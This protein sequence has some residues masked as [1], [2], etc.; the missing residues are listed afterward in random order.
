MEGVL[1]CRPAHLTRHAQS[2]R[3]PQ[4]QVAGDVAPLPLA[5]SCGALAPGAIEQRGIAPQ[6]HPVG[7]PQQLDLPP[8]ERLPGIPLA[9]AMVEQ[10]ADGIPLSEPVRE[11][12]RQLPLLVTVGCGGPLG[13]IVTVDRDEGRLA[14]HRQAH[15]L[16]RQPVV[17]GGTEAVDGGPGRRTV[18]QGDSRILVDPAHRVA[19]SEGHLHGLARPG[20]RRRGGGARGGGQRDVTFAGEQARGG[21]QPDPACPGDI[22]LGPGVQVGEVGAR[23]AGAVQRLL[24]RGELDE[25]AGDEAG[26]QAQLPQHTDQQPGTVPTAP[27]RELHGLIGRLDAMLHTHRVGNVPMHGEIDGDE[28]VDDPRTIGLRSIG[29]RHNDLAGDPLPDQRTRTAADPRLV[30]RPQI[31]LEVGAQIR[32]IG[33]GE[34]LGILLDKEIEGVDDRHIGDDADRDVQFGDRLGEDDAGQ[35]V[36]ERVLLP[37]DEVLALQNRQG[38]GVDGG[39]RMRSGPQPH[40]MRP[41][42]DRPREGVGRAV[43]DR[44]SN[45]HTGQSRRA[46][47][48]SGRLPTPINTPVTRVRG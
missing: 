22:D 44:H 3:D 4:G 6:R 23:A 40:R 30:D 27:Q 8:W 10:A 11:V 15:V 26:G 46:A 17:N 2:R 16:R 24:V 38:V 20:D 29:R 39:A 41:Q 9:L 43:L 21:V 48:P 14:P 19:E 42:F 37:V 1:V 28:E 18:G 34:A 12:R 5:K 36:A 25:I 32:W 31:G 47:R 33:K 45:R 35:V 7:A 13:V